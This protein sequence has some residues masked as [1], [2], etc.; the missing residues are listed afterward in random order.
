MATNLRSSTERSKPG[1]I[2]KRAGRNRG[3]L[4]DERIRVLAY[5]LYE[6]R[7]ADGAA[8]DA[9]S[10]WIEAERRLANGKP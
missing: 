10:D 9:E 7:Q 4:S 2:S 1:R 3:G 8:G 5:H 6:R